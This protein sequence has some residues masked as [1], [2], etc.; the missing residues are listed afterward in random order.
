MANY[1]FNPT[2]GRRCRG[3]LHV[4]EKGDTLY[5]LGKR[6]GVKVSAIMMANPYVDIYNL[7]IGDELCIPKFSPAQPG[8]PGRPGVIGG[9]VVV[10]PRPPQGIQPR[11]NSYDTIDYDY[12]DDLE[13]ENGNNAAER[14]NG[15]VREPMDSQ[16]PMDDQTPMEGQTPM[17]SQMPM[18]EERM[19]MERL[20]TEE[21]QMPAE[22]QMPVTNREADERFAMQRND[23]M[24]MDSPLDINNVE[25][26]RSDADRN[27]SFNDR[28][29][30][31][32]DIEDAA[33][34]TDTLKEL[35]LTLAEFKDY[36]K[37]YQK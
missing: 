15:V 25:M 3:I 21:S 2:P 17:D 22:R 20:E 19:P 30:E 33:E 10:I 36:M 23:D 35:K 11:E 4:I 14:N 1:N 27:D 7:Q 29:M 5:K 12:L 24:N 13:R 37:Q 32:E 9:G 8:R 18:E 28:A 6:Y 26:E 31:A 16:M 34:L